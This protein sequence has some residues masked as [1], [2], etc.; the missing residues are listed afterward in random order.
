MHVE[1]TPQES[2]DQLIMD[3]F[4]TA[5]EGGINYWGGVSLY[6]WMKEDGSDDLFGFKAIVVEEQ[7]ELSFS[8]NR[9]V[10][11]YGYKLATESHRDSLCW[12]TEVPPHKDEF[13]KSKN[14][15]LDNAWDFDAGDADMILQ[16]GIFNEVIYG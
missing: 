6:K 1:I 4:T 5:I 10:I 9:E 7:T 2:Y 15:D 13:F 8:V 16:L 14:I 12:S 11:E 3:I